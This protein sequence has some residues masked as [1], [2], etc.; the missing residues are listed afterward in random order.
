MPKD[1]WWVLPIIRCLLMQNN[2]KIEKNNM[3]IQCAIV[4]LKYYK[5]NLRLLFVDDK[6]TSVWAQY[7]VS[8][9]NR[10]EVQVKLKEQCITLCLYTCQEAFAYLG[11]KKGD[12]PIKGFLCQD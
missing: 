1:H 8:V 7:S 11:L 5:K 3:T 10:D 4:K 12:F 9:Q 2:L 6:A